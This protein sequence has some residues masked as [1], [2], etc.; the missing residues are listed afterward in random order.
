[1]KSNKPGHPQHAFLLLG[2]AILSNT[3]LAGCVHT[4]PQADRDFGSAVR[5]AVASQTLDPAAAAN[6][7]PV[8]GM[9]G[10]SARLA[11]QRHLQPQRAEAP[12]TGGDAK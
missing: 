7:N 11:H 12:L 10:T 3:M 9:D 6:T 8:T 5:A 2:A 1:M 4:S